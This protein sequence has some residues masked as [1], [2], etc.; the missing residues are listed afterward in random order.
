MTEGGR[1]HRWHWATILAVVLV[2]LATWAPLGPWGGAG[3]AGTV[4]RTPPP[5]W[6]P[7]PRTPTPRPTAPQPP[8]TTAAATPAPEPNAWLGLHV[9]MDALAPG[10]SLRL[11][12]TLHN[13]GGAP[14]RQA[15]VTLP[16]PATIALTNMKAEEGEATL[17][18]E[19]LVWRPGE[20]G[21]GATR[22]LY[23]MATGADDLLPGARLT[24]EAAVTW[25]GEV[26][27]SNQVPL[28]A[29]RALLPNTGGG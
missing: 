28:A 1:A 11:E 15:A 21:V 12:L 26:R 6:T 17:E 14:L 18:G 4:P 16:W 20:L 2:V 8:P 24:L 7:R 3:L 9:Q 13:N 5:T 29:P 23:V 22:R 19:A 27:R 10:H 25:D